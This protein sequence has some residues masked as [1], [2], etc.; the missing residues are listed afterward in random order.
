MP[1]GLQDASASVKDSAP[2]LCAQGKRDMPGVCQAG[3]LLLLLWQ[4][5]LLILCRCQA[6]QLAASAG[7][8]TDSSVPP[9][10]PRPLLW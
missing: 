5:R 8:D 7:R 9:P 4:S 6:G 10:P 2:L 1:W 3:Q